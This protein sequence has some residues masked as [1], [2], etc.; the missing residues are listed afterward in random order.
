MLKCLDARGTN[1]LGNHNCLGINVR[2]DRDI[3]MYSFAFYG[4]I[5]GPPYFDK[6]T[7]V[8][9]MLCVGSVSVQNAIRVMAPRASREWFVNSATGAVAGFVSWDAANT[10]R[11]DVVELA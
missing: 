8:C 10:E 7:T 2:D 4:I 1:G 6:Y 9:F 3:V 11:S 5:L